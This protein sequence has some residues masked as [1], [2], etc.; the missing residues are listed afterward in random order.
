MVRP[1]QKQDGSYECPPSYQPCNKEFLARPNGHQY[2]VCYKDEAGVKES[3]CP[4][5]DIVFDQQSKDPKANYEQRDA[6]S[7]SQTKSFF[8]SREVMQHGIE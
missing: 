2:V 4:I 8:F 6:Q 7:T 1:V 3:V 5:T